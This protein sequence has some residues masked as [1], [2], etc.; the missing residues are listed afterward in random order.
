MA[1]FTLG[2]QIEHREICKKVKMMHAF[3]AFT[4]GAAYSRP[5]GSCLF[6]SLF[7]FDRAKKAGSLFAMKKNA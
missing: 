1:Q 5:N 7:A 6:V 2:R 4:L 3:L